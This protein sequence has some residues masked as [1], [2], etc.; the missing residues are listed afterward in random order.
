MGYFSYGI[1]LSHESCTFALH[2][3][4]FFYQ[5]DCFDPHGTSWS[6]IH[7]YSATQSIELEYFK[8]GAILGL[9]LH[10]LINR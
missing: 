6:F 1:L 4:T 5:H 10:Y 2:S 3:F 7:L 9:T 8:V